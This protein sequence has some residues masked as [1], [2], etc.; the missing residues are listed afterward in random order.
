[1]DKHTKGFTPPTQSARPSPLGRKPYRRREELRRAALPLN[2]KQAKRLR[3]LSRAAGQSMFEVTELMV[4]LSHRE[5]GVYMRDV[6]SILRN[7]RL[8]RSE[9]QGDAQ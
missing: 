6:K 5:R 8:S 2:E 3:R 1:M 4:G 7:I 9:T